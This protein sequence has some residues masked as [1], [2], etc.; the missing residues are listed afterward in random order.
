MNAKMFGFKFFLDNRLS[1]KHDAP[2][3]THPLWQR[4][5]EDIFRFMYQKSKMETQVPTSGMVKIKAEDLDPYPGE[6]LKD[7]LEERI[8]RSNLMLATDYLRAGDNK[9]AMECMN[10][11][12]I[13]QTK[14]IPQKN[15]FQNLLQLQKTWKE[16]MEIFASDKRSRE[17]CHLLHYPHD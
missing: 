4:V 10:N 15:P 16:L 6:F 12:Y 9:G 8:F 2:P 3:K 14:A 5:R 13:A 17:V 7:D 1:I 11:I